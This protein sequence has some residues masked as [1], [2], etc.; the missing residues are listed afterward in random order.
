MEDDV[1]I[2]SDLPSF[3]LNSEKNVRI[4]DNNIN[5]ISMISLLYLY[6]LAHKDKPLISQGVCKEY[7]II[8]TSFYVYIH[9]SFIKG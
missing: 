5:F 7:K 3:N 1:D 8:Y 2:Y 9:Y 4:T 6:A